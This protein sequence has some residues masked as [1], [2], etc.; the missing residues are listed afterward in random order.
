ME[1]WAPST[2]ACRSHREEG[3]DLRR[4]RRNGAAGGALQPCRLTLLAR[5][6]DYRL[7]FSVPTS[8]PARALPRVLDG[9]EG[10]QKSFPRVLGQVC[11][12]A[13]CHCLEHLLGSEP[14]LGS[15]R[16][17]ASTLQAKGHEARGGIHERE[18]LVERGA[19]DIR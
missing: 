9:L 1:E 7:F 5:A 14:V 10:V 13:R 18:Y 16:L 12:V 3:T 19:R 15:P 11:R 4:C 17:R 6:N 8:L 2:V